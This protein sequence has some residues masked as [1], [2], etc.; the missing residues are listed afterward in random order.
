MLKQHD[1]DTAAL[2]RASQI[3]R[4]EAEHSN[5]DPASCVEIGLLF[6]R[7]NERVGRYWLHRALERDPE[8]QA[9]HKALAEHYE[10]K[11]DREKAASHRLHLKEDR[12]EVEKKKAA[13][14]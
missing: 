1:R 6:L 11:G 12:K 9:A 13:T 3:L 2:K 10:S 5:I 7:S 14:P 8:N 4:Q